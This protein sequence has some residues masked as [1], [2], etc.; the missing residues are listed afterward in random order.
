M[1][2]PPCPAC[3]TPL[4]WFPEMNAWGC[5]R[6][7]Q[8]MPAAQPP[9]HGGGH[10]HAPRTQAE[11]TRTLILLGVLVVA[12]IGVGIMLATD[13]KKSDDDAGEGPDVEATGSEPETAAPAP[14][15]AAS[16]P[17][18][19]PAATPAPAGAGT[20]P[21]GAPINIPECAVL[22]D[23][24]KKVEACAAITDKT[25]LFEMVDNKM[26]VFDTAPP[27][28][29]YAE[30]VRSKC[31]GTAEALEQSLAQASCK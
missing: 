4:R 23:L 2:T 12:V 13:N 9:M 5:D 24:R 18:P 3:G 22:V 31:A 26:S 19:P 15:P 30:M 16:T 8:M 17:A 14:A 21:K 7:Q 20:T 25:T 27:S 11:K 1:Q 28:G 29:D 6:C 10:A